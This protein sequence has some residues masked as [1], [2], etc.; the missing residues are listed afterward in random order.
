MQ[1]ENHAA[2][3]LLQETGLPQSAQVGP[4]GTSRIGVFLSGAK[5]KN[6]QFGVLFVTQVWNRAA[7]RAKRRSSS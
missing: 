6:I 7:V 3:G 4:V 2:A 1:G 5:Y